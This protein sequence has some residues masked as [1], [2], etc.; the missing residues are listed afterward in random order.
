MIWGSISRCNKPDIIN[1][2][3]EQRMLV[4]VRGSFKLEDGET[5]VDCYV[6]DDCLGDAV[7]SAAEWV[8]CEDAEDGQVSATIVTGERRA[9]IKAITDKAIAEETYTP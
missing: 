6:W 5:D 1:V 3:W 7:T 4:H 9:R 8:G 2:T